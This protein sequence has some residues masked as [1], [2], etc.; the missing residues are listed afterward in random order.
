MQTATTV[1]ISWFCKQEVGTEAMSHVVQHGLQK[2]R[3]WN[4]FLGRDTEKQRFVFFVS[5]MVCFFLLCC[6]SF[7]VC[8]GALNLPASYDD[9]RRFDFWLLQQSD[10]KKKQDKN[11]LAIFP[12]TVERVWKTCF[13]S[14]SLTILTSRVWYE[15]IMKTLHKNAFMGNAGI[16]FKGSG[17]YVTEERLFCRRSL[18]TLRLSQPL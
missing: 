13:Y 16:T 6:P 9:W 2:H 15:N 4:Y 14:A 7:P 18:D 5:F 11:V 8:T 1:R 3:N 12:W 17:P 10:L